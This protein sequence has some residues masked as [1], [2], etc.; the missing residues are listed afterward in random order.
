MVTAGMVYSLLAFVGARV[1]VSHAHD[2]KARAIA[3]MHIHSSNPVIYRFFCDQ[4]L[5]EISAARNFVPIAALTLSK[6]MLN[7]SALSANEFEV[8]I[9][10]LMAAGAADSSK[11]IL[12]WCVILQQD[13]VNLSVRRRAELGAARRENG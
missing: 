11:P 2:C 8:V 1:R 6:L 5:P 12:C 13:T 7:R 3:Q 9:A 10:K 4:F